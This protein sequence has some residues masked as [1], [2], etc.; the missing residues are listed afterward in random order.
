MATSDTEGS[1]T[2]PMND[3]LGFMKNMWAGVKMPGMTMPSLSVEDIDK[4]I[5][6]LKTVESWLVLNM[7][8]LRAT[9]QALEVQSGTL[10][11]LH[12]MG[13]SVGQSMGSMEKAMGAAIDAAG[14]MA[15]FNP[16]NAM[17]AAGASETAATGARDAQAATIPDPAKESTAPKE[18]AADGR[19]SFAPPTGEKPPAPETAAEPESATS[20]TAD[21]NLAP[22]L[23]GVAPFV[24]PAAW[25]GMLQDQFNQ[26]VKQ[27]ME[28]EAGAPA[29]RKPTKAGGASRRAGNGIKSGPAKGASKSAKSAAKAKGSA[30]GAK[31]AASAKPAAGRRAK[32][33]AVAGKKPVATRKRS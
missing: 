12:T 25:W 21:A 28:P 7:N 23:A 9:I 3:T 5:A 32:T 10:T 14:S 20:A 8:M 29:P 16:L 31:R 6:D 22:D 17:G 33:S 13:Q 11:A 4:Q 18:A 24:N 30:S 19:F 15:A 26:A 27:A 1:G 2:D